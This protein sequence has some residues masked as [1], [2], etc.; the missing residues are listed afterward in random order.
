[1][2]RPWI[3]PREIKIDLPPLIVDSLG[4]GAEILA[5]YLTQLAESGQ[6]DPSDQPP[7]LPVLC[8]ICERQ[9]PPWWFE[10]HTELCLQEHRAEMDVQMAQESL[11]EH[12]HA[13][14]KV[15]DALE[16]RKSRPLSGDLNSLPVAEY[17]G[18]SIGP[19]SSN[20]S[21]G[22]ASPTPSSRDRSTGFGHGRSRSFA[23]R[24]PQ[25]RIVELL[26]DLCDTAIEI[27]TPAIKETSSQNAGE[28]RTQSP[29]SESRISQVLQWQSPSTNTLDQE[30]GLA[31]LCAD[32]E[33]VAKE[34]VEA[35]FRHR[36][37]I[38]YAERIRVEFT[39]IV[40]DCIDEAMRKAARIAAGRLSDSTES[41]EEDVEQAEEETPVATDDAASTG[42]LG[43]DP[44]AKECRLGRCRV[45]LYILDHRVH[46]IKQPEGV[47][48]AEIP[49]R[50]LEHRSTKPGVPA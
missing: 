20:S 5:S 11:T 34:K 50:S 43:I 29:Q 22:A 16:A 8:R 36:K 24:R 6:E 45:A 4:S 42:T 47:P 30:L 31:A 2:I 44:C 19:T 10:K 27:S 32:T 25:A 49:P 3:A 41:G 40:Q 21:P 9:I 15:L 33:R 1:M 17:K 7:P 35:V 37:I 18:L 46:Q 13:I 48:Y 28:L 23:V 26:L 39:V 38:E 12:R 14:V